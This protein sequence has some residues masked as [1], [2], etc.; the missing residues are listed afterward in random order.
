MQEVVKRLSEWTDFCPELKE[1]IRIVQ[2]QMEI[3]G[4]NKIFTIEELKERS[5]NLK[6]KWCGGK[7]SGPRFYPHSNGLNVKGL[8]KMWVYWVCEK[9][10]Y[11]WSFMKL[12]IW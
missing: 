6:C 10:R 11:E 8:G 7:L 2:E 9:C 5:K 3:A 12:G 4:Y 1:A